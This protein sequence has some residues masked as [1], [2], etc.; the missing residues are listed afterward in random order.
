MA[1]YKG[2]FNAS[3]DAVKQINNLKAGDKVLISE[4]C[5]HHRQCGDIGTVKI[6][7]AIK[8]LCGTEPVFDFS[9]G[10][11][12]PEDLSCYKIV[13]HCGGCMLN[14]NEMKN[15]AERAKEQKVSFTN[16]GMVLAQANGILER[17]MKVFDTAK[18]GE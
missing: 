8:K 18:N 4:G 14:E 7:K 13:V 2:N 15:R 16:Y 5:T 10:S 6:P 9:S 17:S 3:L 1:R 12:F 11:T